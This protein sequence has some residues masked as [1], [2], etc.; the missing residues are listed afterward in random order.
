MQ[1][2]NILNLVDFCVF[3]FVRKHRLLASCVATVC[4][5]PSTVGDSAAHTAPRKNFAVLL[6]SVC[7]RLKFDFVYFDFFT[8]SF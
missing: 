6:C 5:T 8:Q 3:E 4:R 2:A 7:F 1:H